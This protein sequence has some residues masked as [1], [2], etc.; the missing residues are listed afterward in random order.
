MRVIPPTSLLSHKGRGSPNPDDTLSLDVKE[1]F[2]H[3]LRTSKNQ[4]RELARA[5]DPA[6]NA[7]QQQTLDSTVSMGADYYQ[8]DAI[9]PGVRDSLLGGGSFQYSRFHL[10]VR[11]GG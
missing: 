10:E 1:L 3:T 2:K 4:R 8:V 9:F 11:P 5:N 6:G 7:S